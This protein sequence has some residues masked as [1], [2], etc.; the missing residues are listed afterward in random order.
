MKRLAIIACACVLLSGCASIFSSPAHPVYID[1]AAGTTEFVINNKNGVEIAR[2]ET[3]T[4]ITLETGAGYFKNAHYLV[5]FTKP[6]YKN[7]TYSLVANGN[8]WYYGNLVN[9]IG[10]FIDS[11]TG[12]M[13]QLPDSLVAILPPSK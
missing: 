11:A 1:S 3:P 10:F 2:G 8:P 13:W 5:T 12:A 6:H 9:I 4:T 7:Q